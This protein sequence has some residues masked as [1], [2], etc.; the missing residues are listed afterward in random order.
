MKLLNENGEQ[1]HM[2]DLVPVEDDLTLMEHFVVRVSKDDLYLGS[3]EY[4]SF[5]TEEQ[6]IWCIKHFQGDG[7]LIDKKYVLGR[8]MR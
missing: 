8:V 7:C 4:P 5:P 1:V 3:K 2:N 6:I